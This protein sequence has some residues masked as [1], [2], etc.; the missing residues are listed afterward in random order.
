MYETSH[1]ERGKKRMATQ[2]E[3]LKTKFYRE[4]ASE[5]IRIVGEKEACV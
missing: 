2:K 5:A 3:M 1:K 4:K